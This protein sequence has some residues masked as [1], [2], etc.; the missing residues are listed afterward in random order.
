MAKTPPN[1][2][3]ALRYKICNKD[4]FYHRIVYVEIASNV[5]KTVKKFHDGVHLKLQKETW[6]LGPY[7][8]KHVFMMRQPLII[9]SLQVDKIE[10]ARSSLF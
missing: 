7:T 9:C 6:Q 8:I 1:W 10:E 3:S 2:C 4:K 5:P